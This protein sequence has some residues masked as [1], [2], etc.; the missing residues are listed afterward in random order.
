MSYNLR[1]LLF[2]LWWI[3]FI[4][5]QECDPLITNCVKCSENNKLD[6]ETCGAGY[7]NL[8]GECTKNCPSQSTAMMI[9][10][11]GFCLCDANTWVDEINDR[12]ALCHSNCE[13]CY[14]PSSSQCGLDSKEIN[15]FSLN[16][17]MEAL[18]DVVSLNK[19]KIL[20]IFQEQ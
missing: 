16:M 8:A 19:N 14:G 13:T 17:G 4:M 1:L 9:D 3:K 15:F 5:N 6:C 18:R 7:F 10:G 20:F 2:I 11:E 12:C